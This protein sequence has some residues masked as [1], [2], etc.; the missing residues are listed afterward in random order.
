MNAKEL[1]VYTRRKKR[2]KDLAEAECV[3]APVSEAPRGPISFANES[4]A[5]QAGSFEN[6][7]EG[8]KWVLNH[9]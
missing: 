3:V 5:K 2:G 6:L 7:R 4:F 9:I 8:T 1:S